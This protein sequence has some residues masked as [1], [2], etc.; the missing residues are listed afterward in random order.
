MSLAIIGTIEYG[1]KHLFIVK[2]I[3][4]IKQKLAT[5]KEERI[6]RERQARED[7]LEQPGEL[8]DIRV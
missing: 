1:T 6:E 5:E 4:R 8:S 3:E 2:E 7:E